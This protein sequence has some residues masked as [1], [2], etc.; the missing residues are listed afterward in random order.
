METVGG[1]RLV[2]MLGEGE[3]AQTWLG[4]A[5][6]LDER[7]VAIKIFRPWVPSAS[8][9]DEVEALARASSPHL[10]RLDDLATD[11]DG[12]TCLILQ[13]LQPA[14]LSRLV[15]A[16]GRLEPGE[17]VTAL[18]PLVMAVAELHRVGVAHGQVRLSSAL[19]DDRGAP[20]LAAFG[21][22]TLIGSF[23]SHELGSSLTPAQLAS[24]L[25]VHADRQGLA[26]LTKL[27][28][29]RQHGARTLLE[30]LDSEPE[31]S[32]AQLAER[33]FDLAPATAINPVAPARP[34]ASSL[35][36]PGEPGGVGLSAVDGAGIERDS[37]GQPRPVALAALALPE[38]LE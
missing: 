8:I 14:G 13:R 6:S 29:S 17:A 24:D 38:W 28:L 22:A 34:R 9:S 15:A 5:G 32:L 33:V 21:A 16:R 3:R 11:A 27:L 19:L 23:P 1:Y 25:Q 7:V 12:R 36:S 10:L 18:A 20:V 2:R 37:P 30:W 35:R 31:W 26:E 4:H